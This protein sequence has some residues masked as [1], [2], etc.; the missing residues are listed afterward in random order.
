MRI[1]MA[2]EA[3]SAKDLGDFKIHVEDINDGRVSSMSPNS[4]I[5]VGSVTPEYNSWMAFTYNGIDYTARV[6]I[7]QSG[8]SYLKILSDDKKFKK[9][10]NLKPDNKA[11]F[12]DTDIWRRMQRNTFTDEDVRKTIKHYTEE[13]VRE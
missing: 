5:H 7:R 1:I 12:Y 13:D 2:K 10:V 3:M 8:K 11:N 9:V 6:K 4:P